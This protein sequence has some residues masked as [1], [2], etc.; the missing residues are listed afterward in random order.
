M[1]TL[2]IE[3]QFPFRPCIYRGNTLI[4]RG[5]LLNTVNSNWELSRVLSENKDQ[6]NELMQ[7][8]NAANIYD[9]FPPSMFLQV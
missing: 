7:L 5:R 1:Y 8:V 4:I 2:Y 3:P 9:Q 6:I